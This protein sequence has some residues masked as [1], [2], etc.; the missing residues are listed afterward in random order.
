MY[1]KYSHLIGRQRLS[2]HEGEVI[3]I[4]RVSLEYAPRERQRE[5]R[6]TTKRK[7]SQQEKGASVRPLRACEE[8]HWSK[9]AASGPPP[10]RRPATI[11]EFSVLASKA[12]DKKMEEAQKRLKE[13]EN[14]KKIMNRCVLIHG[15]E[16]RRKERDY[17]AEHQYQPI[18]HEKWRPPLED[19]IPGLNRAEGEAEKREKK[20]TKKKKKAPPPREN[21]SV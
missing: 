21:K 8:V 19:E 3:T 2:E 10:P 18:H 15:N 17:I 7:E 16:E 12:I 9:M 1:F 13:S 20:K 6:E 14:F 5:R 11:M 4:I